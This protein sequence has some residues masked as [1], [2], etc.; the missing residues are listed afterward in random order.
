MQAYVSIGANCEFKLSEAVLVYR[1]GGGGA[2]ASLHQVRQTGDGVPYLAPGENLTTA[3]VRTL[4]QGLGAQ[5]KPDIL[6][7]NVL[8]RTPDLL[9]WWSRPRRRIMFFGGTDEEA[10]KLNGLLFPH[11][12]LIFKVA[13]KDLFVRAMAT[14]SRPSS[15]TPMKTAPYWNTDAR[16]LVCAG[17]MRVPESADIA[18]IPGWEGAYFQSEFTHAAGAVRLTS[19]PGGFIGLWRSLV[20]RKRFPVRYLTDTGETL[21]EFVARGSER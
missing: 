19:H 3:F 2:F 4:A 11:P 12:A 21:Q 1:G 20:G 6:P 8:V 13:G 5:V 18:S 10:R 16:G 17:S 7:D 14:N 9:V 15:E